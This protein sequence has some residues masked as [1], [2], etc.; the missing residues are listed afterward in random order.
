MR[1]NLEI[2]QV[3]GTKLEVTASAIDLVKFEERYDI[4]VSR[5]DKEMKLTHL[6]FLAHTSLKRQNKTALDFE[7]W[8][9]TVESVGASAKDPK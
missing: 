6:L 7:A 1:I 9:E 2:E 8:L 3:D 4:S 5:L